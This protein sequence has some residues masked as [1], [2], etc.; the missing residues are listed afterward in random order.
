MASY[1][2]RFGPHNPEETYVPHAFEEQLVDLGEV[3]MNYATV[4]DL[5]KPALLLVPG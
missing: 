2:G 4:G 1:R 3:Q 5:S